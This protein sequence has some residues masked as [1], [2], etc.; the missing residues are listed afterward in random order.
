MRVDLSAQSLIMDP[1]QHRVVY[2]R[3][4]RW[5]WVFSSNLLPGETSGFP[6]AVLPER[7]GCAVVRAFCGL[8]NLV[9]P[10]DCRVCGEPLRE[11]LRV[12]VCRRCLKEPEP[13]NAE[14]FCAACRAPFLNRAPLDED[15][16]CAMCRLG[17]SGF[18]S[19]FTYGS[20]EG[21]LRKL[22][23]LL[24][25][26]G[27]R[28]LARPFGDFLA[29]ALPRDQRFD[30]VVPMPLHWR[31]RWD[32]GF[33]QAEL[34]A[35]EVA[36]RWNV[37]VRNIA[38]RTRAT[39]PQAGLTHAKRRANVTGAFSVKRGTRLDGMRVLLV[40]DVLTTGAS[41][42]ACARALKRAGARHVVLVTVAR[43]D[44]RVALQDREEFSV[45]A[46]KAAVGN[47]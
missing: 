16:Q 28:P 26:D 27:M 19:A 39:S 2:T 18:D 8:F 12:P 45:E 1:L 36:K 14:F 30:L 24:K 41:A 6:W 38:R 10:D 4:V 31:R 35:C 5:R 44:R 15:G 21:A 40:D 47:A 9:L 46:A 32:R 22:I 34:L 13:L 11:V 17:L 20:Y 25:Y 33:N 7:V 29:R 42:G 23:H 37:P 3:S 43:A